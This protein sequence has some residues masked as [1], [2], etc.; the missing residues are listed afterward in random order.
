MRTRSQNQVPRA[1]QMVLRDRLNEFKSR[2][3]E[4]RRYRIESIYMRI[5]SAVY[6]RFGNSSLLRLFMLG[7][8]YLEEY[9]PREG[10]VVIDVG[11]YTGDT[12]LIFSKL[13][14]EK[15]RVI[16]FEPDSYC[17]QKLVKNKAL[18]LKNVVALKRLLWS[19]KTVV[20]F[21]ETNTIGSSVFSAGG[22]GRIRRVRATTLD[23]ELRRL[24]LDRVDF[25]KMDVEGAEIEILKGASRTLRNNAPRLAIAT[26][27]VVRGR[28]TRE[29]V[30]RILRRLGYETKTIFWPETITTAWKKSGDVEKSWP[31]RTTALEL[32]RRKSA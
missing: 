16:C 19:R 8:G 13:V 12:A 21:A 1:W 15:G 9:V 29:E 24:N 22:Y 3:S 32:G 23:E 28:Q 30:E 6:R 11:A 7:R 26:Y 14:G 2:F 17:F 5:W 27:H 31:L 25:I 18:R 20:K 10:D 4:Q